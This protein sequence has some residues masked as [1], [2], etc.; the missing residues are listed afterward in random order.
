MSKRICIITQSHLCRNPRVLKEATALAAAGYSVQILTGT[1][2][3]DLYRQDLEA[4]KAYPNIKLQILFNVSVF[5]IA[6]FIDRLL[7]RLGRLL[8]SHFKIESSFALAYGSTRYYKTAK[9]INADLYICHQEMAT[10]IGTKLM[11]TGFRV[12]FDFEDWYSEDLL[13]EARAARPVQLLQK[14]EAIALN[15][16]VFCTTTS[17]ALADKLSEAYSSPRPQVIYNVFPVDLITGLPDPPGEPL[18]L[19]WFSQTIGPGRGLEQFIS[20]CGVFQNQLEFHLLGNINE[21]YK[22]LLCSLLPKQHQLYFHHLVDEH[23]LACKIA[24]FDIGLA[25]ELNTPLSRNYTITNKFFQYIQAGLPVIATETEGQY[26]AFARYKPGFMLRQQ[27]TGSEIARLKKWLNDP[28]ALS[29]A[30]NR[31]VEAAKCYTWKI[32]SAKLI[33]LIKN[34]L[35]KQS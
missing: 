25:L 30:K 22:R 18:K 5:T 21:G 35:E 2:S 15:R 12:A 14:T 20:L 13:P 3:A 31:A 10:Y 7:H 11:D 28:V 19:F 4:I 29:E 9:S 32:E 26:E 1:I 33:A 24:T 27:P 6:S 8:V 17:N 34:G 23:H 16:G